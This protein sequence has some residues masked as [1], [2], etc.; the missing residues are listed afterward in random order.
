MQKRIIRSHKAKGSGLPCWEDQETHCYVLKM[1]AMDLKARLFA[2][3]RRKSRS[4]SLQGRKTAATVSTGY[5]WG[6]SL[7]LG[8][9]AS[10]CIPI[11]PT[12]HLKRRLHW[13]SS[14][15]TS[16]QTSVDGE[17]LF[18]PAALLT[19]GF[20]EIKEHLTQYSHHRREQSG[21][22]KWTEG[23]AGRGGADKHWTDGRMDAGCSSRDT[24]QQKCC[25]RSSASKRVR[26]RC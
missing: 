5:F 23:E 4:F 20:S 21:G 12:C 7:W 10:P 25:A 16:G 22:Q 17:F 11:R 26:V 9:A 19:K 15:R 8:P 24:T 13:P 2:E 18:L 14:R 1:E 3:W 6:D